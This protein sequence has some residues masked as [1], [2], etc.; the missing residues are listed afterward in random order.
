MKYAGIARIA[1]LILVTI[2][3]IV[4][5]VEA[6]R[7]VYDATRYEKI[8]VPQ[9]AGQLLRQP[10]AEEKWQELLLS[11][12][13]LQDQNLDSEV[14]RRSVLDAQGQVPLVEEYTRDIWSKVTRLRNLDACGSAT[15]SDTN[16]KD[17]LYSETHLYIFVSESVPSATIKNYLRDMEGLGAVLVLRGVIGTDFSKFIPTSRWA[18]SLL[19]AS[20]SDQDCYTTSVEINPNLYKLF[21]IQDV[22]TVVYV[23][24]I[25]NTFSHTK[26]DSKDAITLSWIGD[27]S[28]HYV[29]EQ[30]LLERP[31]DPLLN[32]YL[33][34]LNTL[35]CDK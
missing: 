30:F 33:D 12:P 34:K 15:S 1:G 14:A 17:G 2:L 16:V 24:N 3:S 31:F 20:T 5:D 8:I 28:L 10:S 11:L 19:C 6:T 23:P 18:Q 29:L 7:S 27:I 22:P 21:N 35:D 9:V 26:I 32:N 4:E 25:I 13:A